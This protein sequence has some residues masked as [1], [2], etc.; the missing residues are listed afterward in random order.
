MKTVR[1]DFVQKKS[2]VSNWSKISQKL[3]SF[4]VQLLTKQMLLKLVR[5]QLVT[6]IAGQN[7]WLET[8]ESFHSPHS[9]SDNCYF[10]E[11]TRLSFSIEVSI[12]RRARDALYRA[13]G[14]IAPVMMSI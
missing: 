6:R 2:L 14:E 13:A 11:T 7:Y 1:Q 9:P 8:D 12:A 5:N 10:H 4:A 3:I